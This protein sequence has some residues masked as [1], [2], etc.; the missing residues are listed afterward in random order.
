MIDVHYDFTVDTTDYWKDFWLHKDGLGASNHDPD[1]E[2]RM[3]QRY[4]QF[5]WSRELP[6]G[7]KMPKIQT[8]RNGNIVPIKN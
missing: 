2:S 3:L 8:D 1:S 5:L 7:K 6:C 4:H